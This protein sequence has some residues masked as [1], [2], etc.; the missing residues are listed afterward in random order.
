MDFP[1]LDDTQF[2]NLDNVNPYG[3]KNEFDYTRWTPNTK[4]YLVN[5]RWNSD[6]SDCVKFESD[7]ARDTWFDKL[8]TEGAA[9]NPDCAV[10]LKTNTVLLNQTVKVPIPYDRASQFNYLVVD[11]PVITSKDNMIDYE[12]E[13]GVK[14]WHFFITGFDTTNPSVTTLT[15][16]LDVWTQYINS[17][18]FN[19]FLL[20][21][22]HAPVAESD[23]DTYLANPMD[24]CEYLLC[25]DVN[26]GN[27]TVSRGGKFIPFGNGEKY[28]CFAS[29]CAASQLGSVGTVITSSSYQWSDPTF[30]NESAYPDS[31]NRWGYQYKVSGF[32]FGSGKSYENT[33]TPTGNSFTDNG[34]IPNNVT[35]YAIKATEANAFVNDCMSK[36]PTFLRTVV[37]CFMVAKEMLT[38]G[39]TYSLA[40]HTL[41]AC[42]GNEFD[43]GSIQLSKDMFAIPER[44]QR[45]AKLYTFPYSE[46][47]ITDNDG[48]SVTVRVEETSDMKAHGIASMAYPYLNMRM[49]LTGIGGVGSKTY[50]WQDLRGTHDMEISNGD[51]FK[52]CYDMDVPMYSLYMDG[53]TSWE[54]GNYNRSISNARS[55][56]LVNYHNSVRE[57]NNAKAN[58]QDT[59]STVETNA[60]ASANTAQTNANNSAS[61]AKTNENNNADVVV[62]NTAN[63]NSCATDITANNNANMLANTARDNE[64]STQNITVSNLR[65]SAKADVANSVSVATA[66][67]ENQVTTSNA[68][69]QAIN[70]GAT[71]AG[72]I[73]S[74]AAMGAA[75]GAAAGGIGALPGAGIGA[76]AGA[77]QSLGTLTQAINV[78]PAATVVTQCNSNIATTNNSGNDLN[79]FNDNSFNQL[80]NE[81]SIRHNDDITTNNTQTATSNTSRSNSCNA[82][83]ANNTASTMRTNANNNYSTATT[84]ASN[85]RN[86]SVGNAER[87]KNNTDSTSNWTDKAAVQ[88][89]QDILRNT[90][91]QFK[92]T[93]NDSRNMAPVQL[94]PSGGGDPA[95]D[96][97]RT[98]GVQVK[99][100]TQSKHAIRSA[101]DE[102]VRFGYALNQI[103]EVEELCLMNHFTYWKAKDC[104]VYEKCET[105]DSAQRS[106]TAIFQ[107]GVTVWKDPNEIGRVNPY[108]N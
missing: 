46:L 38:L 86:T 53:Q 63:N 34:R 73:A 17:V 10:E 13:S 84:N 26:Y 30:S 72:N 21:R 60:K 25:P 23:T 58:A 106:I 87:S 59:A 64:F 18:G 57:A 75:V 19:Y 36:S 42:S 88:G 108:D 7:E 89:A 98:R 82:A 28:I 39:A 62:N 99:A 100:R 15:L 92:A 37:A 90:Q 8:V 55:S 80:S 95:P 56:A 51:W 4:V 49:F 61:T 79:V 71:F 76:V 14:R 11:V 24:N 32:N 3:Y 78:S 40:G 102:F 35:V 85:S 67:E 103:W 96:Y 107:N 29:T 101:G 50:Q 41:Y 52:F 70:S 48:K 97:M 68:Q 16:E 74:S 12:S 1:H 65:A 45:F 33:T 5:V 43:L 20:E 9:K 91:A 31:S 77:V 83:N 27:E 54:I 81:Y 104:W 22:G 2:P 94:C 69:T 6:Y 44:Y 93:A 47:E 105:N 66:K